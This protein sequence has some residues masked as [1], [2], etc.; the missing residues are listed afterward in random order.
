M[1]PKEQLQELDIPS[2]PHIHL[3][4]QRD[5]SSVANH[6]RLNSASSANFPSPL[7]SDT[8]SSPAPPASA[9]ATTLP[10]RPVDQEARNG[11]AQGQ[12]VE[13]FS[14]SLSG[15][16]LEMLGIH[17]PTSA[18][19]DASNGLPP[20]SPQR[21]LSD[22]FGELEI[23]DV[24][25]VVPATAPPSIGSTS[26]S[27]APTF[28]ANANPDA[29]TPTGAVITP[30]SNV[31]PSPFRN[32]PIQIPAS[33]TRVAS[34]PRPPLS[35]SAPHGSSEDL[36]NTDPTSP[37]TKVLPSSPPPALAS[38][39]LG[40][41]LRMSFD[42]LMRRGSAAL[43]GRSGDDRAANGNGTR[44]GAEGEGETSLGS[45]REVSRDSSVVVLTSEDTSMHSST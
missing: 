30:A 14:P 42:S 37:G 20:P 35:Q 36:A 23:E 39:S 43:L 29:S 27:A 40:S 2:E 26:T 5:T 11:D 44:E 16:F 13:P 8:G 24:V 3:P 9:P 34:Y 41:P 32:I 19:P 15:F 38:R 33:V 45:S 6:H 12:P 10:R 1:H 18:G 4:P 28:S 7:P 25:H 17:S 22:A 31:L 21:D